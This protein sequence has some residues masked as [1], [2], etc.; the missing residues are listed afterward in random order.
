VLAAP[1]AVRVFAYVFLDVTATARRP[2]S[3]SVTVGADP[4]NAMIR[5]PG[6]TAAPIG[7]AD[8]SE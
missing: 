6:I 4:V 7:R 1:E 5:I 3:S 2:R 8:P